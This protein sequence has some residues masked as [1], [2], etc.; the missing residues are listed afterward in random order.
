MKNLNDTIT[1]RPPPEIPALSSSSNQYLWQAKNYPN[2]SFQ[3]ESYE[4]F[5]KK[6]HKNPS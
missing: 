5:D 4:S 3:D 6:S 1:E 2:S